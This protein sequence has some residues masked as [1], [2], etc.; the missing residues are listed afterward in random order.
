MSYNLSLSA[1][2]ASAQ[3]TYQAAFENLYAGNM[4]PGGWSLW[5]EKLTGNAKTISLQSIAN[6]PVMSEWNG[7]K[8]EKYLR[9][10]ALTATL[11]KFEATL[12][13]Q[14]MDLTY[15][16]GMPIIGR[17]IDAYLRQQV[18]AYDKSCADVLDSASGAGPTGY[19]LVALF[20]A[21]HPHGAAGALQSNIGAGVNLNW[22]TF[23]AARQ[24]GTEYRFENGEP[25]GIRYT[26]MRVGPKLER[27]AKEIL[28]AKDRIAYTDMFAAAS[29]TAVQNAT[30]FPNVWAG[31]LK[32][33]VD[34]RIT[35][36][37]WDLYDLSKPGVR[38]LM[39][40][41]GRAPEPVLLD[42]M[43]GERRF[44]TDEFVFGLEGDWVPFAGHWMTA[45]RGTG[46]AVG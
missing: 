24:A 13:I 43:D 37:Y 18:T 30:L 28:E 20:S 41:E 25:A 31:E 26:H 40:Y 15:E 38:P 42:Q 27:V 39:L 7:A 45:Y 44:N 4:L 19:D 16:G 32:L 5:T 1:G 34:P 3:T 36:Y 33:V 29:T 8:I 10:Y 2:L 17:A 6:F 9:H 11:K 23:D 22:R 12:P 46:T 21:S 14:R 35:T